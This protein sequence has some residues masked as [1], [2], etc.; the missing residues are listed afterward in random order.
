[1]LLTYAKTYITDVDIGLFIII[2]ILKVK[3]IIKIMKVEI[4]YCC[5]YIVH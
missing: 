1:M 3:V 5:I 2:I 4:N